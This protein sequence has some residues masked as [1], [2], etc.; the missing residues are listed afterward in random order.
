MQVDLS[1]LNVVEIK[2]LNTSKIFKTLVETKCDAVK[3]DILDRFDL[4]NAP[5]VGFEDGL[6]CFYYNIKTK[7]DIIT[8]IKVEPSE[9]IKLEFNY[10]IV[11]VDENFKVYPFLLNEPQIRIWVF[12]N[13]TQMVDQ[14]KISYTGYILNH[15]LR[16]N[17]IKR[18]R[19]PVP[20]L[21][22][23]TGEVPLVHVGGPIA[24]YSSVY[25]TYSV[26]KLKNPTSEHQQ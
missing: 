20:Y 18:H 19:N 14:F 15:S 1:K 4:E 26:D 2:P 6:Y 22:F 23:S 5:A 16:K 7:D 9:K 8:N 3:Y 25:Y 10:N 17:L 24:D 13:Q 21:N 12:Y 11:E